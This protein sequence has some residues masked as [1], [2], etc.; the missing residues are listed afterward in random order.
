MSSHKQG[1]HVYGPVYSRRLGHSLGVDL[2]PPKVCSYDCLYCQLG[3]TTELAVDRLEFVRPKT[4]V[5]EVSQSLAR[6]T[7]PDYLTLSGSGEPTLHSGLGQVIR[8]LKASTSIPVAVLTN[9]SLLWQPDVRRAVGRADLVLPSLDAG[10]EAMFQRVNRPHRSLTFEMVVTCLEMFVDEYPGEVWLEVFLMN[11]VNADR[12]QVVRIAE[13][14]NRINPTRVQLNTVARPPGRPGI[15]AVPSEQ[16]RSL[17]E[18]FGCPVDIIADHACSATG[19]SHVS[20][21]SIVALISR[22]PSTARGIAEGLG[23]HINEVVKHLQ[24]LQD[25]G[26]VSRIE[27]ENEV[28]YTTQRMHG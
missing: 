4:V 23:I 6:G 20:S 22:R 24:T 14:V 18:L 26:R 21:D 13:C 11:A 12:E 25:E 16:L 10:D 17:I 7:K 3:R 8:E 28:F 1:S 27:Q 9:G 5:A 15:T 2:I 19:R